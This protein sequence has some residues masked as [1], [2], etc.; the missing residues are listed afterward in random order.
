MFDGAS[1]YTALLIVRALGSTVCGGPWCT[2]QV[3]YDGLEEYCPLQTSA[4]MM[5]AMEAKI[6]VALDSLQ[7]LHTGCMSGLRATL[8]PS[9]LRGVT[10]LREFAKGELTFVPITTSILFKPLK[11]D[12]PSGSVH[13]TEHTDAEGNRFN[14]I[15][16]HTGGI[17]MPKDSGEEPTGIGRLKAPPSHFMAPFWLVRDACDDRKPN[18]SVKLESCDVGTGL[19]IPVLTNTAKIGKGV[20]LY[21][22]IASLAKK[23]GKSSSSSAASKPSPSKRAR[24]A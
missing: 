4:W 22:N 1:R 23:K 11:E 6:K 5:G 9:K 19:Q 14:V 3:A 24:K 15:L 8:S 16:S 2:M 21:A 10:T 18:L 12:H 20:D 17:K 13:V 7:H